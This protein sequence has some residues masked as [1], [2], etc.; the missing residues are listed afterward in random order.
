M[1]GALGRAGAV[2]LNADLYNAW[3]AEV[4][5]SLYEGD[6]ETA[7]E[8]FCDG[9]ESTRRSQ[10]MRIQLMRIEVAELEARLALARAAAGIEVRAMLA[11]AARRRKRLLAEKGARRDAKALAA[12]LGAAHA[13]LSG[14]GRDGARPL[15]EEAVAGFEAS[16]RTL[17]AAAA[18]RRL[19]EVVGGEGGHRLIE[20]AEAWMRRQG[21]ER[22]EAITDLLAPGF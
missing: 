8:R 4:Q 16:G 18:R 2:D 20:K 22:P 14:G 19:G 17:C 3:L 5:V 1:A 13:H 15:L 9:A 7:W 11:L 6:I 12:L 21:I 10:L